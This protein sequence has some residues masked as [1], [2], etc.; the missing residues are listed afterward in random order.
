[1]LIGVLQTQYIVAG[2]HLVPLGLDRPEVLDGIRIKNKTWISY[3]GDCVLDL[4]SDHP[5]HLK[6]ACQD[7]YSLIRDLRLTSERP[8]QRFIVQRPSPWLNHIED[9]R[10][11]LVTG[12]RPEVFQTNKPVK[13]C[14]APV[15]DDFIPKMASQI[16]PLAVSLTG[17]DKDL[18]MRVSFG[19]LNIQK[20]KRSVGEYTS[21]AKLPSIMKSYVTRGGATLGSRCVFRYLHETYTD[22]Y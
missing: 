4:A 3:D 8:A 14:I 16:M 20:K 1:M 17:L 11:S 9:A 13:T 18:L 7:L 5:C 15:V 6:K 22:I 12:L 21:Y 2:K 10:V 19:R